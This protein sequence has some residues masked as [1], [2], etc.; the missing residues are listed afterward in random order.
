MFPCNTICQDDL[1]KSLQTRC[2]IGGKF[3]PPRA[4]G[5]PGAARSLPWR[6]LLASGQV[7]TILLRVLESVRR[8][9]RVL[10]FP[11]LFFPGN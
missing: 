10:A 3:P 5:E 7:C 2:G 6:S 9:A 8:R 4:A 1:G 11:H